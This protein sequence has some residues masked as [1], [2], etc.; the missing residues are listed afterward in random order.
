MQLAKL[1]TPKIIKTLRRYFAAFVVFSLSIFSTVFAQDNSPY[2]RY[3]LG[4]LV[5][6]TNIL[7]RG[8]GGISAANA[9]FFTINFNNPA[10]FA[11]FQTYKELKSKKLVSGRAILDVGINV[12]NRTIAEPNNAKK[13][14]SSDALFSYLQIGLPLKTNWG[15]SFGLRPISKVSYK[16]FDKEQLINPNP[17]FNAIDTAI[18]QYIGKGG[19]YLASFGTGFSVFRKERTR[20]KGDNKGVAEEKL[21]I[22]V[23]GGYMF[24]EKNYSTKRLILN[25]SIIYAPSN[26]QTK[27]NFHKLVVNAG[28][29]YKIPVTKLISV[30]IGGYGNLGYDANA[31]QDILRETYSSTEQGDVRLDSV[32]DKKDIVG[33]ISMPASYTVGFVVQKLAIIN[34]EGGWLFGVDYV[35]QKWGDYRFYGQPDQLKNKWEI[36]AGAQ[37]NPTPKRNYF[38]NVTYRFGFFTGPD[39]VNVGQKLT[40][41]GGSLGLGLPLGLSRQ[42]PNQITLINIALE[43]LK[44]GN[45]DNILKEN[46]FRFSLGLSLSDLWFGKKKYD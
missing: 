35:Q 40:Q 10:S 4:D 2:S 26:Y 42:A 22:G 13:F 1:I 34:K 9:D 44:R 32:A 14:T 37:I 3:G 24:G 7:T 8:M 16:I 18:T 17:P 27:T 39:Y 25:D 12:Q 38:S 29:Q 31:T 36:R 30:T 19:S 21:S 5:P 15:I 33:K 6:S 20:G 46:I 43:Y 11:S 23:T 41:K 45:N 28:L